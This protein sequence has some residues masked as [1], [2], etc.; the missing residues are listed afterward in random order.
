ML[1]IAML[2]A[3]MDV[4][5]IEG[6][7][8]DVGR[9]GVPGYELGALHATLRGPSNWVL[10]VCGVAKQA[11]TIT[12][13]RDD[14]A[15]A[16]AAVTLGAAKKP[17][18]TA[19]VAF[20]V[21]S[22]VHHYDITSSQPLVVVFTPT[23]KLLKGHLL[24]VEAPLP[25]VEPVAA[26]ASV[27]VEEPAP[28]PPQ[29]KHT[30]TPAL[31]IAV[32]DLELEGVPK[33]VGAVV[34]E[35]VLQEV[36]KLQGASAIGMNEIRDMLAHE[37][38]KQLAGCK[39]DS[40]SC[41]A[42]LAGALGVDDLVTGKL[43]RIDKSNV[44]TLR[45]I[46]QKRAEVA[47]VFN[48]RLEAGS[49]QE[50]LAT[51]GPAV[52]A[53]YPARELKP[54]YVRGVSKEVAL[55]LDP[56]PVPV[57]ATLSLGGVAVGAGVAGGVVGILA[58]VSESAY[59]DYAALGKSQVIDG[60]VLTRKG[61]EASSRATAANVLFIGAGALAITTVVVALFTDWKGYRHASEA[62]P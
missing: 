42:D 20:A 15:V 60:S 28:P 49:G 2:L 13:K 56:P 35:S 33:N 62:K 46:D 61:N 12:F 41:M 40:S 19:V 10:E 4:P 16:Q 58:L 8:V 54:G 37:A 53:L 24:G 52:K 30:G 44:M 32:Y 26:P 17:N 29:P 43:A 11:S 6:T 48:Q 18:C 57:W 59:R 39:E 5:Q 9:K 25:K 47:G 22:G 23:A 3:I 55:R 21:A 14:V 7:A 31:R 51:I 38:T 36:R 27:A 34:T 1:A 45:R 50:F